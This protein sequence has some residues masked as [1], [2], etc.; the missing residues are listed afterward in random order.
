MAA[1]GMAESAGLVVVAGTNFRHQRDYLTTHSKVRSGI[2]GD[3]VSANAYD[4]R[5]K[6]WHVK[7]QEQEGW[8]DMEAMLRDWMNWYWLSVI[9][10]IRP[11]HVVCFD[12]INTPICVHPEY[13]MIIFI[14]CGMG[15]IDYI[16]I[17]NVLINDYFSRGTFASFV[18]C[19]S[20]NIKK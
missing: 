3:L 18:E 14:P 7:R 17:T 11:G 8:S 5:G 20:A 16:M 9:N 6:I 19:H 13:G 1:G 12:K 10:S 2:I 15:H 4:I